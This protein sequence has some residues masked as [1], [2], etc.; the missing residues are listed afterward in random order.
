MLIDY[1]SA[2]KLPWILVWLDFNHW[3][4]WPSLFTSTFAF[5]IHHWVTVD[6]HSLTGVSLGLFVGYCAWVVYCAVRY[7]YAVG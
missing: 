3:S 5:A 1:I 4:F 2:E 6:H 7:G